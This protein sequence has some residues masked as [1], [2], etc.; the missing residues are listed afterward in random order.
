MKKPRIQI[1]DEQ[2]FQ[3]GDRVKCVNNTAWIN[4][5]IIGEYGTVVRVL[6]IPNSKAFGVMFDNYINGHDLD[7]VGGCQDGYGYWVFAENIELV[8]RNECEINEYSD[9]ELMALL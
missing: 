3:V 8:W 1:A 2:V 5:K 9:D 6:D 7:G 4:K